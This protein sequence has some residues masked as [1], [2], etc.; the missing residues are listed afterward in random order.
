MNSVVTYR[1]I[2]A[3]HEDSLLLITLKK[4]LCGVGCDKRAGEAGGLRAQRVKQLI[5]RRRQEP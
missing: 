2:W 4:T 5:A 1:G 3:L